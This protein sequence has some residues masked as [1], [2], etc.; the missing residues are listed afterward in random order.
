MINPTPKSTSTTK[1]LL[2]GQYIVY[3]YIHNQYDDKQSGLAVYKLQNR[4]MKEIYRPLNGLGI[5]DVTLD[6]IINLMHKK[7]IRKVYSVFHLDDFFGI[8][9]TWVDLSERK[10]ETESNY[11][12]EYKYIEEQSDE[13]LR[14]Q[15]KG[16][17][18]LFYTEP[19]KA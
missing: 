5:I 8:P 18:V 6:E 16:I 9:S 13:H 19:R 2:D 12:C 11:W 7:N 14:L 10:E 4:K 3:N 15:E 17:E 1:H